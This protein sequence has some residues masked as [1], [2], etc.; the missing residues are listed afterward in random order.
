MCKVALENN[1]PIAAMDVHPDGELGIFAGED[2]TVRVWN[3]PQLTQIGQFKA[4]DVKRKNF[5]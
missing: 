5:S 2:G 3:I 1:A 4:H